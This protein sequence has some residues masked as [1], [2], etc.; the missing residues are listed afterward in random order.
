[1]GLRWIGLTP[2]DMAEEFLQSISRT[3]RESKKIM[4]RGAATIME[5][6]QKMAP[7]DDGEL[8]AAHDIAIVRLNQDDMM[9]E[10]TV[11]GVVNGVNV[12]KYAWLQHERLEPYGPWR[13]GPNSVRKDSVSPY[14]V[15]GKFLERAVDEHE[16]EIIE[17]MKEALPGR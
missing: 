1:M 7:V 2:A 12:D 10:I 16:E 3:R 11:G 13:L 4:R 5:T 6:S 9:L 17:E 15:G 8:E 14:P